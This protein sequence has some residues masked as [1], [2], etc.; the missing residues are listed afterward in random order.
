MKFSQIAAAGVNLASADFLMGVQSGTTDVLFTPAQV[1]NF[2]W[3]SP[4][5]VTPNLGTPTAGVLTN[6]KALPL[7]TGV[8]G[9]LPVG[10][11]GSGIG[12]SATTYWR[13]DGT[14][15]AAGGGGAANAPL[16]GTG[17]T[18]TANAPLINVTQTWNNAGVTFQGIVQNI[19]VTAQSNTSTLF[20]FQ[21]SGVSILSANPDG[22]VL[23][24]QQ[25][26]AITNVPFQVNY[27][28]VA[29]FTV[30]ISGQLGIY[31]DLNLSGSYTQKINWN[32]TTQLQGDEN[33]GSVY[34]LG[35]RNG[36]NPHNL[37]V[38]NTYSDASNFERAT[39]DWTT[40]SNVLTIGVQN[41]GTGT[42]R[43]MVLTA[44]TKA[45]APTTSDIPASTWSLVRDSSG[46]T[47]KLYYN[48]AGTLQSVTL[49]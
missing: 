11:L 19:T 14:W 17:A 25:G 38:Y 39:F 9:N 47:T 13:G 40:T 24:N 27:Q 18:I 12:A 37:R 36:A 44:W 43:N 34:A 15:A 35:L 5:L 48:N 21:R 7:T 32:G 16:T 10:N 20:D 30:G 4:A 29:K 41:A 23:V 22:S 28:G 26:S 45:G 49:T 8:T 33:S 2:M 1:A 6:C 3:A 31:G 46:A 42:S